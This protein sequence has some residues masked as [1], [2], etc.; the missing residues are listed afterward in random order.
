MIITDTHHLE[1]VCQRFATFPY[2]T[3][4]T[5]F[6]RE[7]TFYPEVC[8]IQIASPEEAFCVDP[9]ASEINLQ[10]LFDLLQNKNVVKVFHAASQD[11]EILYHL[12]GNIPTPIFDTQI[13]A[14]AC[15]YGENVSYQ[16]LVKSC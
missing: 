2:M 4:D 9:L 1:T 10:P 14:M 15:G 16:Q 13:G 8:L 7:K 11:L 6:I 5:E 3:I 12:T